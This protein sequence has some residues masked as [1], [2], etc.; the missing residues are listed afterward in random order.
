MERKLIFLTG[1]AGRIGS[2]LRNGLREWYR[3]RVLYHHTVPQDAGASEEEVMRGSIFN[4]EDMLEAAQGVDSIVHMAVSWEGRGTFRQ[5]EVNMPGIYNV[6]EAA[7]RQGVRKVVYASTN[8]VTGMYEQENIYTTPDMP[9]R[10]DS[11]YGVSKAFGE[12]LGRYFVDH[13]NMSVICLRIGSFLPRPTSRRALATWMS[14][15]DM[16]Q[17]VHRALEAD[18][19]YGIYYGISGNT[20]R[21]WDISN[22][23]QDLGYEPQD[24]AE[25]YAAEVLAEKRG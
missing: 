3:L 20:R 19:E 5:F 7:R 23:Q 22:A 4:L 6:Y 9:P 1:A 2:T 10:P 25:M 12:I 13:H 17:L 24:D 18:V 21:Y 11:F 14:P 8:H 15:R 16:V